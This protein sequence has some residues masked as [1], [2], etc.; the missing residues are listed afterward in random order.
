MRLKDG[1]EIHFGKGNGGGR[2][3]LPDPRICNLHLAVC[4]VSYACGA[5]EIFDQFLDDEDDDRFQVPV[6]FGGPFVSDD[7]LIRKL[8]TLAY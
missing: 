2:V 5:S 6:Y 7:V 8:E 1:D 4:R 3:P